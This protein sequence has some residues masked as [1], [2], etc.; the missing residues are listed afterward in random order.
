MTCSI[1]GPSPQSLAL[2]LTRRPQA[3]N[4]A[5]GFAPPAA[6]AGQAA[7]SGSAQ[8]QMAS[9]MQSILLQLQ[10]GASATAAQAAS[11]APTGSTST[12]QAAT[13]D[14]DATGATGNGGSL[15]GTLSTGISAMLMAYP[16]AT[17]TGI[18]A[19]LLV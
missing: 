5:S 10:D 17:A 1:T 14:A 7:G 13:S 6:T 16:P 15:A 12:T 18:A 19:R 3:G 9:A 8:A 11:T 4:A 2:Q